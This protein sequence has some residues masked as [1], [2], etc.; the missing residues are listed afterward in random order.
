MGRTKNRGEK[1]EVR[2]PTREVAGTIWGI[3]AQQR[4]QTE[5]SFQRLKN[6]L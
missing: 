1:A 5:P 2:F 3:N 6:E 4:I